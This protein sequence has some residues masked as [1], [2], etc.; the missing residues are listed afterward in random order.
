[1]VNVQQQ[2]VGCL[3]SVFCDTLV[4]AGL[5]AGYLVADSPIWVRFSPRTA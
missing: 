5:W 1:M 4:G 2:L 3:A